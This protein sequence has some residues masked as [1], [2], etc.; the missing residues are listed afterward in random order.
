MFA[1]NIPDS[2]EWLLTLSVCSPDLLDVAFVKKTAVYAPRTP[3]TKATMVT[4]STFHR[5]RRKRS[6]CSAIF[7]T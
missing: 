6:R 1:F 4:A 2:F 5:Y 7:L 3:L